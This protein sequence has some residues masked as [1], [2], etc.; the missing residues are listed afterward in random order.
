MIFSKSNNENYAAPDM[1]VEEFVIEHGFID[2]TE[3]GAAGEAGDEIENNN[4][5]GF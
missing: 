4:F 5:G 3:Y 1:F 2:S